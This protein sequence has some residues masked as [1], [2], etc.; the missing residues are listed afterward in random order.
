MWVFFFLFKGT[1][2]RKK[3]LDQN[4]HGWFAN[5]LHI[6]C[7]DCKCQFVITSCFYRNLLSIWG[8]LLYTLDTHVGFIEETTF[9]YHALHLHAKSLIKITW[10]NLKT[11]LMIILIPW[12][13]IFSTGRDAASSAPSCSC[14]SARRVWELGAWPWFSSVGDPWACGFSCGKIYASCLSVS[15]WWLWGPGQ[16]TFVPCSCKNN[17]METKIIWSNHY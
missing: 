11:S 1:S 17:K 9:N 12:Q 7:F 3:N 14:G 16:Q 15:V 13:H 10:R 2:R 8:T 5:L 6:D 4:Y